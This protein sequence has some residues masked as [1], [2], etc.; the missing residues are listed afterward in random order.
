[1][2]EDVRADCNHLATG[3]VGDAVHSENVLA[4]LIGEFQ[5]AATE[6]VDWQPIDGS[7]R[8]QLN[9]EREVLSALVDLA[10]EFALRDG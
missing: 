1:M 5:H 6:R 4:R 3:A 9:G 7:T 10:R 2:E 8:A